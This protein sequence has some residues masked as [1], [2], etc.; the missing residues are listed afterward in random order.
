MT[1]CRHSGMSAKQWCDENGVTTRTHYAWQKKVFSCMVEQQKLQLE[2]GE[3]ERGFVELLPP[4]K[5]QQTPRSLVANIYVGQASVDLY[6]R[7]DPKM[8]RVLKPC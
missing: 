6:S 2:A 3:Q 1:G 7:A 5:V 4:R 8:V